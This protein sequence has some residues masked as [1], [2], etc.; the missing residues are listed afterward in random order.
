M[1]EW[2][3]YRALEQLSSVSLYFYFY[4][5]WI[6]EGLGLFARGG[7]GHKH[8]CIGNKVWYRAQILKKSCIRR[9]PHLFKHK[10]TVFNCVSLKRNNNWTYI[11]LK[12]D[13][14]NIRNRHW[15]FTRKLKFMYTGEQLMRSWVRIPALAV[16]AQP[17]Q[18]FILPSGIV[19]KV[20]TWGS[21]RKAN[22]GNPDGA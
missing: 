19:K 20:G 7:S 4:F 8:W 1:K 13:T 18:L 21:L 12:P 16:G 10:K 2:Q 6:A 22:C 3:F 17:S 15:N 14:S 9:W 5:L 11:C